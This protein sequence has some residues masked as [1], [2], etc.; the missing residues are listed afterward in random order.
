MS[1]FKAMA[2]ERKTGLLHSQSRLLLKPLQA[3]YS[4]HYRLFFHCSMFKPIQAQFLKVSMQLFSN[5]PWLLAVWTK[6]GSKAF[7]KSATHIAH[8]M[9]KCDK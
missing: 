8:N 7:G 9:R 5:T 1:D 4:S 3:H 6:Q 2:K